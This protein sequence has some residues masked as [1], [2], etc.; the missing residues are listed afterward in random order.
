MKRVWS[1]TLCPISFGLAVTLVSP[2]CAAAPEF[3]ADM[4]QRGPGGETTSGKMVVGDGRIRTEMS[5]QGQEIVRISDEGRGVEWILFPENKSYM[6]SRLPGPAGQGPKKPTAED[7]CAGIPGVVCSK[8]GEDVVAG[9]QV[10]VW[11]IVVN[12]EGKAMKGVQWIDKE[13][14]PAFMLRQ[15][16]PTGEKMERSLVGEETLSGRETEKWKIEMTRPDGQTVSTFEWYDPELELAIKQEFPGGMVSE[17]T[18]IRVGAQPD[19]LFG[20]PAGYERMSMPPGASGQ[21]PSR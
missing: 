9:R 13:R 8:T 15:E 1:S 12:R 21:Q 17:I 16:L 2:L 7:P 20:V 4:I 11:E 18:N 5:H 6:E 3:S 10:V 14:G 19:Q